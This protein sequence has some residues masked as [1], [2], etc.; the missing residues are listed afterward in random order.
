M[1]CGRGSIRLFFHKAAPKKNM[2]QH[3]N[4]PNIILFFEE[5]KPRSRNINERIYTL[6]KGTFTFD[7]NSIP[8][9]RITANITRGLFATLLHK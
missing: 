4:T 9:Q 2:Q 8:E 3:K 1:T 7:A 5:N 6:R